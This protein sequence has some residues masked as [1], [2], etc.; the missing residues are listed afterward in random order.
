[1]N[2]LHFAGG[3]PAVMKELLPLINRDAL[4]VGGKTMGEIAE[5]AVNS[6]QNVI[7]TMENPIRKTGGLAILYGNIAPEGAVCKISAVKSGL[8]YFRCKA[9]VFEAMEEAVTAVLNREIKLGDVVILKYEGPVGGPGMREMH[10]VTSVIA[11][12][13]LDVP[14]VTDG[15]FSGSTR[16]PNIGHVSPEAALGGPIGIIEEGDEIEID[17]EKRSIS[18][19]IDDAE[20]ERR[21]KAFVPRL[22]KIPDK[23]F[24]KYYA[25]LCSSATKGAVWH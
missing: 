17:F 6:D 23:G 1:V 18:L 13:G 11:G 7:H 14:L 8:N 5:E 22:D 15:R 12:L 4:T 25:R 21:M 16:G 9:R 20:F 10:L 24:L 3:I 2:D 19:L